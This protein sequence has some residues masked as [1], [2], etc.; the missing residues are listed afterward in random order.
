MVTIYSKS[1]C[2]QCTATYRAFEKRGIAFKIIDIAANS[3]AY[4]FITGL[5]YRQLPVVVAGEKHWAG[6]RPD[7]ISRLA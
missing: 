1:S 5:G 2:M 7:I 4:S 6:F 3:E